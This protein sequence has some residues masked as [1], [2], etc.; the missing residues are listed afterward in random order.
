LKALHLRRWLAGSSIVV[1]VLGGMALS[2]PTCAQESRVKGAMWEVIEDGLKYLSEDDL[3]AI[4]DYL[5]AQPD[6]VRD[7]A[8]KRP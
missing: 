8:P 4:G 7:V 5:F 3:E 2:F 6:I 1:L